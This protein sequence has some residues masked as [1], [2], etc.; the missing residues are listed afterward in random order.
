MRKRPI[1]RRTLLKQP[2]PWI[3]SMVFISH[4]GTAIVNIG[5]KRWTVSI[6]TTMPRRYSLPNVL[7]WPNMVPPNLKCGLTVLQATTDITV[8]LT[9]DATSTMHSATM[10]FL[11]FVTLFT[12]LVQ[13][14]S[15]GV[16]AVKHAGLVMKP[17]GLARLA[18]QWATAKQVAKRLG[19]GSLVRAMPKLRQE[20]GS[21]TTVRLVSLPMRC[22]KSI[23]KR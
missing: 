11:T 12:T 1:F 4:L 6:Q 22:L 23:L 15:F 8:V 21:T 14:L 19:S 17:D 18:G 20:V 13:T 16:Q 7:K 3:W 5:A 9:K 10:T 2:K